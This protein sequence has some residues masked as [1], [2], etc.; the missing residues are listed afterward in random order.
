MGS[1]D[2]L[3][4]RNFRLMWT[5]AF[6]SNIGTWMQSIAL[7][8]Y[9][10]LLTHSAFWV[11]FITFANFF[12]IVVS[13]V[14]GVYTD[15]LDRRKILMVTQTV[16]MLDATALTILAWTGHATLLLVNLLT[17][18]QGL[19]FAFNGPTWLAFVPSLVPP[20][21]LVNAIALNSAQF[22]L[23]RVVGPAVAGVLISVVKPAV[24]FGINAASFVAVLVALALIRA[25]PRPVPAR[26]SVREEL[27][28]GFSYVWRHRRIRT[29]IGLIA[30]TSFFAAPVS[31]L[32]PVFAKDVF[33]GGAGAFGILAAAMGLGS[34]AGALALGRLG[35]RI[36]PRLTSIGALGIAGSLVLFSAIHVYAVGLAMIFLY[37]ATYLFVVASTNGDIQLQVDEDVR[38]RVLS[39]YL[40]AFGGLFPLGS[41]LA[42]AIAQT[43][44]APVTTLVGAFV[45]G[46]WALGMTWRGSEGPAGRPALEPGT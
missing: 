44:G 33:G 24:V 38:G 42:G 28:K 16:M 1:F 23:A 39:I 18:G 19:A 12:P 41:L 37:G 22:S 20:E 2:S 31:A 35:N 32:L 15:R 5:G 36:S 8:W 21:G 46:V 40:L 43:W 30:V 3:R 7:A 13:P 6:L 11:S 9:V 29:M 34:V 25:T 4:Y 10:L 45:C 27:V 17:F 14:G 26:R